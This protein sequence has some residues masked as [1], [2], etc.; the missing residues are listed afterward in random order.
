[1]QTQAAAHRAA[2]FG[3]GRALPAILS[4]IAKARRWRAFVRSWRPFRTLPAPNG[5]GRHTMVYP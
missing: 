3:V 5:G 1:R 4:V 2:A